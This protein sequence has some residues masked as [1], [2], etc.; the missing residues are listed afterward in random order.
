MQRNQEKEEQIKQGIISVCSIGQTIATFTKQ[1]KLA[2]LC[3]FLLAKVT[4]DW[5][6]IDALIRMVYDLISIFVKDKAVT[7]LAIN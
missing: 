7:L 5:K 3:Q 1:P 2:E 6:D 4:V